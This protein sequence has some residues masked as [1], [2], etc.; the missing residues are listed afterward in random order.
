MI[1]TCSPTRLTSQVRLLDMRGL[2]QDAWRC[3]RPIVELQGSKP[4][5]GRFRETSAEFHGVKVDDEHDYTHGGYNLNH[6]WTLWT[7]AE[8]YLFTRDK[9]WLHEKLLK[10]QKAA[11]WIIS[12]RQATML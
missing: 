7:L 11:G 1:T 8:H 10:M 2:H 6:G 4:F 5:P 12:E 3:L 9:D